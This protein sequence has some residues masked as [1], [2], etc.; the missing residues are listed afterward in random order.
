MFDFV[1]DKQAAS[2]S[3]KKFF[4][5]REGNCV[6]NNT[7]RSEESARNLQEYKKYK[8]ANITTDCR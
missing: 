2:D 7:L 5:N 1:Q 8:W 4:Y 3:D 6:E